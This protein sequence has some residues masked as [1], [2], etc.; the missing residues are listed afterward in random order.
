MGN[1]ADSADVSNKSSAQG[2]T[3]SDQDSFYREHPPRCLSG[4]SCS[5][6]ELLTF[7]F[8]DH[9]DLVDSVFSVACS[10]GG[11]L[12]TVVGHLKQ[13]LSVNG[14][15]PL[16]EVP[17]TRSPNQ[18]GVAFGAS[19]VEELDVA[20]VELKRVEIGM[21]DTE[22]SGVAENDNADEE[23]CSPIEL[24]CSACG[25]AFCVFDEREH[26]YVR[27]VDNRESVMVAGVVADDTGELFLDEIDAPH[28]V[29]VRLAY[30]R[31][32][33]SDPRYKDRAADLFSCISIVAKCPTSELVGVLY[34]NDGC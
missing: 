23:I 20:E 17:V 8:E 21:T 32:L 5:A 1:K 29:L 27:E 3:D 34:Q 11:R 12:F 2:F 31:D 22:A 15:A 25:A 26:G 18:Q 16:Q 7:D 30:P 28:Q 6:T 19:K 4:L 10:C 13:V 33:L 24:E 9:A 14:T